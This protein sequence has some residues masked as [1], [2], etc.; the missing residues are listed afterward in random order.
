MRR[1][2]TGDDFPVLPPSP[3][4]AP[5]VIRSL[6]GRRSHLRRESRAAS[7]YFFASTTAHALA[8]HRP[9]LVLLMSHGAPPAIYSLVCINSL[10]AGLTHYPTTMTRTT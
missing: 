6:H 8:M 5:V 7:H 10:M 1:K 2:K 9:F 3:D 4:P